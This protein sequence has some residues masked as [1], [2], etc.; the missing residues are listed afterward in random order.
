MAQHEIRQPS[1]IYQ[2]TVDEVFSHRDEIPLGATLELKVYEA[3]PE[4]EQEADAFD[5]KS[6]LEAFPHL[7]GTEHGGPTNISEDPEKHMQGFGET[8]NPRILES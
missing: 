3:S 8:R 2:G 1:R 7:F 6:I 5:G 4:P